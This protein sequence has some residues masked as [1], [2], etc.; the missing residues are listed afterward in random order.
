MSARSGGNAP[1]T[2]IR[3]KAL[4]RAAIYL[5]ARMGESYERRFFSCIYAINKNLPIEYYS[6]V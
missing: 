3:P 2:P 4:S 5:T 1:K 6:S